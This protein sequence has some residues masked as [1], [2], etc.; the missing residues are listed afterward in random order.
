MRY[1]G[2]ILG[3][4]VSLYVAAPAA[5]VT[6]SFSDLARETASDAAMGVTITPTGP[7]DIPFVQSEWEVLGATSPFLNNSTASQFYS[8]VATFAQ[9]ITRLTLEVA[10]TNNSGWSNPI[11]VTAFDNGKQEASTTVNLM[12]LG[13]WTTVT[14][15]APAIDKVNWSGSGWVFHPYF[16]RDAQVTFAPSIASPDAV[17]SPIVG[18]PIPEPTSLAL[19]MIVCIGALA[20]RARP[21]K[22]LAL[23]LQRSN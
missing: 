11:T 5:G 22:D 13:D 16:V 2:L 19:L 14:V 15:S 6:I 10:R 4:I 18:T 8:G 9:P 20:R 23:C 17:G 21:T 12:P 1:A 7:N 3:C